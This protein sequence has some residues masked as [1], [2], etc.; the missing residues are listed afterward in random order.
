[1]PEFAK[2][3]TRSEWIKLKRAQAMLRALEAG[4]VDNWD[5]YSEAYRDYAQRIKGK[6]WDDPDTRD[7][8]A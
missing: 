6:P 8:D 4:G 3:I 7:E 2:L 5:W 1:M